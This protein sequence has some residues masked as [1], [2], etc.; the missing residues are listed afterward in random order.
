MGGRVGVLLGLHGNSCLD[1]I[2]ACS[3]WS[4]ITID[5]CLDEI[6]ACS[7]WSVIT[8]DTYI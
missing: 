3:E 1:E 2:M 8:I 6:M 7:E 5:S 4:V